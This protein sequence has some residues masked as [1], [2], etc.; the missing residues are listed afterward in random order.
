M[1]T[2]K[3]HNC[4][5]TTEDELWRQLKEQLSYIL[6]GKLYDTLRVYVRD[7]LIEPLKDQFD[8]EFE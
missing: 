5:A 4:L 3:L 2:N 8:K 1:K 6:W 7:I